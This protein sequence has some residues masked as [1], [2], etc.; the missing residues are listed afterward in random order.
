M[1][2]GTPDPVNSDARVAPW[3]PGLALRSRQLE[4]Q[5]RFHKAEKS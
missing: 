4:K 1:R 5:I 3:N 2:K